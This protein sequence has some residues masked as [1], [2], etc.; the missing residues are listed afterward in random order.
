MGKVAAGERGDKTGAWPD[1][2]I[3]S[4]K[5]F[6][7]ITG[8]TERVQSKYTDNSDHYLPGSPT[9]PTW[10]RNGR[11]QWNKICL[12]VSDNLGLLDPLSYKE[13]QKH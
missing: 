7:F 10:P 9:L 2:T 13:R 5:L 4:G 1:T 3:V 6:Y 8:N 11:Q 12:L